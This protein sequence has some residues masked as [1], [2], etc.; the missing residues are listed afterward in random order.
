MNITEC[1]DCGKDFKYPSKLERHL[2]SNN[3]CPKKLYTNGEKL[4]REKEFYCKDCE[5]SFST[6]RTFDYHKDFVCRGVPSKVCR[7]CRKVF[8]SVVS[9]SRH[10]RNVSCMEHREMCALREEN[11]KLREELEAEKYK[12]RTVINNTYNYNIIYNKGE[13]ILSIDNP[14]MEQNEVLCLEGFKKQVIK[15]ENLCE[16]SDEELFREG[17][18]LMDSND[19][20]RFYNFLFRNEKNKKLQFM[21][22]GKNIG[23]THT[24]AFSG[25]KV[26]DIEKK[27]LFNKIT[28]EIDFFYINKWPE[29]FASLEK[30][31]TST[32]SRNCFYSTL[33]IPSEHFTY[34]IEEPG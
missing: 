34:F 12:P 25:G 19:F 7:H 17:K 2:G 3:R 16:V 22:L 33:R 20:D 10:E 32:E 26:K 24:Q 5:K 8:S 11:D 13:G 6:E 1:L 9:R 15:S 4:Y 28:N 21:R 31:L 14:D 27:Y 23:Q 18:A 29:A 30:K